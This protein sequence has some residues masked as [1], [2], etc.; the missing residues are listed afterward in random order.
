M[1][2]SVLE[3]LEKAAAHYPERIAYQDNTEA[4]SFNQV[5]NQAKKI[6][7]LLSGHTCGKKPIIV[8][9]SK[10][11]HVP[12][13]YMGIVCAGCY[14]IPLSADL[15]K[16][17]LKTILEIA[18]ADIILTDGNNDELLASLDF[19]G[20][21]IALP[22][23]LD[24]AIDEKEL[25]DRRRAT[26]DTDPLY[27][28]FTS[29]SSGKPKGV[30]TSH[31]SVIDYIDVFAETFD[32]SAEDIFGNQAP[33][34]Y[35]AAIRDI[36]LPMHTGAKTV[37]IPKTLFSTPKL[38]FEYV[39]ENKITT[40]C[41]VS[42][43]LALCAEL[44]TFDSVSLP[45]VTKVF[46]TGSVLPS[47][48]LRTWQ[49]NLPGAEFVNHYGPTEITASCTYYKVPA[50]VN[51]TDVIPI[52]IPFENTDV[53][54]LSEDSSAVPDGEM[55]ELCVRGSSLALG[56]YEDFERTREVFIANPLQ[57]AYEEIIYKTGD[58]GIK[59]PDG[60][61]TFHGRRDFQIKHMGHR[62]ELGE[63][64]ALALSIEQVRSCCCLYKHSKEQIRLFYCGEIEVRE[65]SI[66]LREHLPAYM[67][68]RKFIKLDEMP[69]TF[70]GKIDMEALKKVMNDG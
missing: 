59:Q 67:I 27:I 32:I 14:Y 50:A 42:A 56:Y 19:Q 64:E 61:F 25:A 1:Q 33:L 15:P 63:I 58:L 34:D 55:G 53:F 26:L 31:R 52:G 57:S 4:V 70:N 9:A 8:L 44:G 2:K 20:K 66:Y 11:V 3:Y 47:K 37:L 29:G 43:A 13:M 18:K 51:D 39:N 35:I 24:A 40:L 41:W 28:I 17:R 46:F 68:P 54:L 30:I 60:N 16:P 5:F 12:S 6:G 62:V 45:N 36:Y 49:L 21:V 69:K 65:L 38:L 22:D 7:S 23:A 48:H 10:N